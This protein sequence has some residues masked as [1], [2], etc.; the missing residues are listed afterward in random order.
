MI[1]QALPLDV[2]LYR[3]RMSALE[4]LMKFAFGASGFVGEL[5]DLAAA[6]AAKVAEIDALG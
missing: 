3:K 6:R 1:T 4:R 2:L 5:N